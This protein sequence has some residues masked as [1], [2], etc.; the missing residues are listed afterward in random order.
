MSNMTLQDLLNDLFGVKTS[1]RISPIV[2]NAD[3][4]TQKFLNI[5]PNRVSFVIF[6]LSANN[7]Y[8]SPSNLVSATNGF[9]VAPN[10]GSISFQWDKDFELVSQEWF[11][12]SNVDNSN[13]F[14]LENYIV[15]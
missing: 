10:G 11:F 13:V 1:Y 14:I 2:N 15:N 5:N 12:M 8:I 9:W 6:N 3:I 7:V 4:A